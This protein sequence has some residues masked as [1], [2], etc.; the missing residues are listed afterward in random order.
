MQTCYRQGQLF[1]LR[2]GHRLNAVV[3][4]VRIHGHLFAIASAPCICSHRSQRQWMWVRVPRQDYPSRDCSRALHAPALPSPLKLHSHQGDRQVP[5]LVP[6]NIHIR[7]LRRDERGVCQAD[8]ICLRLR[9]LRSYACNPTL[10]IAACHSSVGNFFLAQR[11]VQVK[12]RSNGPA[13]VNQQLTSTPEDCCFQG[14]GIGVSGGGGGT[15]ITGFPKFSSNS[16]SPNFTRC[17]GQ[18]RPIGYRV[19]GLNLRDA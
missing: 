11:L 14:H 18:L 6:A 2:L 15:C 16:P 13:V 12:P 7:P 8:C 1:L 3:D 10:H 17:A 9:I 4:I 5:L 19:A